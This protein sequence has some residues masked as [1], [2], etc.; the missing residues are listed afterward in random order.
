[1][2]AR[3]LLIIDL[4][5]PVLEVAP[6]YWAAHEIALARSGARGLVGDVAALWAAKRT[7]APVADPERGAYLDAFRAVVERDDLLLLD[8]LQPGALEALARLATRF[9]VHIL[10]L[11]TNAAGARARCSSLG[12]TTVAPVTFVAHNPEGKVPAARALASGSTVVAVVGDTEA[13]A[14]VARA[15]GAPFWG[16]TCGIRTEER[17]RAEGAER[18]LPDLGTVFPN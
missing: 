17:L 10:S 16:V 18:V 4:D 1:M 13:D 8:R 12:I 11:R 6:R 5:G 9:D 2:D 14:A 3:P 15:L 7:G